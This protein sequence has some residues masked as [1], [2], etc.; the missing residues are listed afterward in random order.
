MFRLHD[1]YTR[2]L[3]CLQYSVTYR[4]ICNIYTQME[5]EKTGKYLYNSFWH[6]HENV[7]ASYHY[8]ANVLEVMMFMHSKQQD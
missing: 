4:H 2:T 6:L 3:F 8:I 7:Y 5:M 1:I